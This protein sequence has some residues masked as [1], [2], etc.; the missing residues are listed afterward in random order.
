M[1]PPGLEPAH[2]APEVEDAQ[3][4]SDPFLT[5]ASGCGLACSYG[6]QKSA[7]LFASCRRRLRPYS[8]SYTYGQSNP[9]LGRRPTV[10][11]T[12][13]GRARWCWPEL[14]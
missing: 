1:V 3:R 14:A 13:S 6:A 10:S 11:L 7:L 8:P 4:L 5:S 12:E 9:L 2:P